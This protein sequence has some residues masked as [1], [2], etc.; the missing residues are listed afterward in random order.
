MLTLKATVVDLR[1]SD[2][3]TPMPGLSRASPDRL[4]GRTLD[5]LPNVST[6]PRMCTCPHTPRACS[7]TL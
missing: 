1:V 6:E 7:Q 4:R 5:G 3:I 2:A